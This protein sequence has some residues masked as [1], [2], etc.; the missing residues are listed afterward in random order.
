MPRVPF[1]L[2]VCFGALVSAPGQ[3]LTE[4]KIKLMSEALRA[5]DVGDVPAAQKALA[6]LIALAPND[7]AAQRLR[8]EVEAQ[9]MAQQVVK[10]NQAAETERAEREYAA[11]LAAQRTAQAAAAADPATPRMI[12][13]YIPEPGRP[14]PVS[15]PVRSKTDEAETRADSARVNAL[16]VSVEAQLA[17]ARTALKKDKPDEALEQIDSALGMLPVSSVTQKLHNNLNREKANAQYAR[18]QQRLKAGDLAAARE[19]LQ[20]HVQLAP[21]STR[22]AGLE[23]SI[24]KA[25]RKQKEKEAQ[26]LAAETASPA[27]PIATAV[28]TTLP[29]APVVRAV[30]AAVSVEQKLNEITLPSLNFSGMDLP[31]VVAALVAAAEQNDPAT[32]GPRGLNIVLLDPANRAPAVTLAL[33]NITLG[34]ALEFLTES[35]GYHYEVQ[36][37]AVVIRPGV[38]LATRFFPL[39]R[40]ALRRIAALGGNAPATTA[41]TT[42]EAE[43]AAVRAFLQ[44]AGVAFEAGSTVAYD[45]AAL[46]ITQTPANLERI[47]GVLVHYKEVRQ[48][49]VEARFVALPAGSLDAAGFSAPGAGFSSL[50]A[51]PE[52]VAAVR[53][54][55][56][57]E[58]VELLSAPRITTLSGSA[59]S[60]TA[61]Q[62]PAASAQL[63]AELRVTPTVRDDD[64]SL[65]LD[66]QPKVTTTS[67]FTEATTHVVLDDG[68][69]LI[70][71]GLLAQKRELLIIVT[72]RIV[73][74]EGTAAGF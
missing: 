55:A 10:Q 53:A 42:P 15:A 48:V 17:L 71:S 44:Q 46:V 32:S 12:D 39:S 52:A 30:T 63:A 27:Q 25:E 1:L 6:D 73:K 23:R 67:G 9:A 62:A 29:A 65:A 4:S 26:A 43:T 16:V 28:S 50:L 64:R 31:R 21:G 69:T 74:P 2:L 36:R 22:A 54:L 60:M 5:R 38:A 37:D 20:A 35:V 19:A 49:L 41:P 18:A 11:S 45:G 13:V 56:Q 8:V 68:A 57:K 14:M 24:A 33:R 51:G 7:P 58:G 70:L 40:T 61:G 3:D 47:A 72:A 66:L 34:R 59:A